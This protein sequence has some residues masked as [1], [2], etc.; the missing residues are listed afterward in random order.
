MSSLAYLTVLSFLALSAA[1]SP[2]SPGVASAVAVPPPRRAPRGS[3]TAAQFLSA[4]NDARAN[5]G[6]P[7]LSWNATMAQWAKLHVS[8]LRDAAGCDLDQTSRDPIQFKMFVSWFRGYNGHPSPADVVASF[9]TERQWYD[10]AAD[11]CV[12]GKECGTYKRLVTPRWRQLGCAMVA[13]R[14]GGAV[15]LCGYLAGPPAGGK[16]QEL[17]Y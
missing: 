5:A 14:S 11:A 8:W 9:V 2:P 12:A 10:R 7:P 13:C 16:L 4:I 1:A 15:A 3:S 6:V 17:P